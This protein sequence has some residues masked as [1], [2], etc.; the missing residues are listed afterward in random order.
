MTY[1]R[2]HVFGRGI[3]ELHQKTYST[4]ELAYTLELRTTI[5]VAMRGLRICLL[6]C[7]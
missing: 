6:L 2:R 4:T 5:L 3:R 7:F 1:S